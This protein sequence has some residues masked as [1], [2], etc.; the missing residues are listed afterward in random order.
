[1]KNIFKKTAA[2]IAAAATL[3]SLAVVPVSAFSVSDKE[4]F[5]YMDNDYYYNFTSIAD[6]GYAV[7]KTDGIEKKNV[8]FEFATESEK[9]NTLKVYVETK[10]YVTLKDFSNLCCNVV[11]LHGVASNSS[12][13]AAV[14]VSFE[15]DSLDD[16]VKFYEE[17]TNLD[18]V[19]NA[20]ICIAFNDDNAEETF[21]KGDVNGDGR[22]N[23]AD[24]SLAFAAFKISMYPNKKI[25]YT[26]DIPITEDMLK[27][28]D[29]NQDGKVTAYDS[30]LIFSR[31]VSEYRK[32]QLK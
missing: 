30:S 16:I 8:G 17:V 23:A 7:S 19:T 29:M 18:F 26:P 28:A 14:V 20:N 3:S 11:S 2:V 31:Y 13:N 12:D 22:I 6:G 4:G 27:R 21:E 32:N 1:M 5:N 15:C 10:D 25:Y 9:A 24:A